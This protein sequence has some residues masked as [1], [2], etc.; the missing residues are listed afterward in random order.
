MEESVAVADDEFPAGRAR[1]EDTALVDFVN[2]TQLRVTGADLSMTSL[3]P[4]GRY[5]G[6]RRG[7]IAVREVSIAC[8]RTRT[9][10]SSWRSTAR[11]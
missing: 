5:E 4:T 11:P 8:I 10:S 6:F 9:S 1:L 3:I 2:D 7:T